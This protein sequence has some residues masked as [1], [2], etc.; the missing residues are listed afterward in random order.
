MWSSRWR[1]GL[2]RTSGP[3]RGA[4]TSHAGP[5]AERPRHVAT[6]RFGR[7]SRGNPPRSRS[8]HVLPSF[9]ASRSARPGAQAHMSVGIRPAV[10][11]LHRCRP[12]PTRTSPSSHPDSLRLSLPSLHCWTRGPLAGKEVTCTAGY[13]RR[14]RSSAALAGARVRDRSKPGAAAQ[15]ALITSAHK[16]SANAIAPRSSCRARSA[17]RLPLSRKLA[18][19]SA[20]LGSSSR[21][22][23]GRHA[24]AVGGGGVGGCVGKGVDLNKWQ[25]H[26]TA[27][28]QAQGR[29]GRAGRYE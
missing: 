14:S 16:K 8:G 22:A 1:S 27:F 6:H 12:A 26:K 20:G 17:A 3:A 11:F 15:S 23:D 29:D 28:R 18:E 5:A 25:A 13:S 10:F 9:G 7:A 24:F 2:V 4:L 19:D 21:I